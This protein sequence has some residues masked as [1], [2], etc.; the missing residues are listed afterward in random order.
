MHHIRD[1]NGTIIVLSETIGDS[2]M[3]IPCLRA[4]DRIIDQPVL[5]VTG[6]DIKTILN[7][8]FKRWDF[9]THEEA[10]TINSCRS[11]IDTWCVPK[12]KEW[13]SHLFCPHKLGISFDGDNSLYDDNI[14]LGPFSDKT[15]ACELYNPFVRFFDPSTN[16]EKS[17]RLYSYSNN[18]IASKR[19]GLFPGGGIV[20]KRWPLQNFLEVEDALLAKGYQTFWYIGPK[21]RDLFI[22]KELLIHRSSII[23]FLVSE[24]P[25]FSNGKV[26]Y[27]LLN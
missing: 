8:D 16:I 15:S 4:F 17:P 25:R 20:Q 18:R 21:E 23:C 19:I 6:E 10:L 1:F 5:I 11:V 2:I 22:S 26:N 3:S 24:I 14:K 12:T 9:M 13:I 27:A 7:D